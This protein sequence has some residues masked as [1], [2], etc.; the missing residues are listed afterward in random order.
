[1]TEI[2][3]VRHGN[4]NWNNEHRIQGWTDVELNDSGINQIE[5]AAINLKK[6]GGFDMIITSDLIR[7]KH[8]AEIISKELSIPY[9]QDSSLRERKHGKLEGK[10]KIDIEKEYPNLNMFTI[11]EGR[12]NMREFSSRICSFFKNIKAKYGDKN[13]ILVTHGGVIKVLYSYFIDSEYEYFK[14]GEIRFFNLIN[15]KLM[16]KE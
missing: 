7:A 6:I 2:C 12:E 13:I 4:T 16:L 15:G 11:V 8:S 3:I 10:T 9:F 14:N 5:E 1:M